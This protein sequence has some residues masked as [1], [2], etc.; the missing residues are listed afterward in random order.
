MT[1]TPRRPLPRPDALL[2]DMDG[3]LADVEQSYRALVVATA[4]TFGVE[5]TRADV[6]AATLAGD[7]NNDWRLTQRLLADRGVTASLDEVTARYQARYLGT[8]GGPALRETETLIPPR[9]TV[10][11]LAA[12]LP[13]A[14]VTG[15][16]R[17]EAAWFLR[18]AALD[19]LVETVV[20]M[21]DAPAKPD[22][23]PVRLAL[24]RLGARH[25]WMVGDT[26]DDVRA[27]VTPAATAFGVVA[28]AEDRAAV[29]P[30]L[31]AAGAVR[32]LDSLSDLLD[33]LP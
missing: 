8:D 7:A 2:L 17:D 12:R 33:G 32:V 28:P 26:P 27:A 24:A 3:V 19:G 16:P 29:A 31:L 6:L 4:A 14:V 30:A 5:I 10:E 13:L 22:P 9:G 11:A 23:A 18:H 25:A 21:E 20:A 1:A 15:R